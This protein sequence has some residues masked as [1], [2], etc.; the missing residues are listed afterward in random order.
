MVDYRVQA[1]VYA[2][3]RAFS[4]LVNNPNLVN[5]QILDADNL[6]SLGVSPG[7]IPSMQSAL[8]FLGVTNELDGVIDDNFYHLG[9]YV[10]ENSRTRAFNQI[11]TRAYR[12]LLSDVHVDELTRDKIKEHFEA[13]HSSEQVARKA[14]HFVMWFAAQAGF[15]LDERVRIYGM[16]QRLPGLVT[17]DSIRE[18]VVDEARQAIV[19]GLM[20]HDERFL[21]V[22]IDQLAKAEEPE[23]VGKLVDKIDEVMLRMRNTS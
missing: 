21:T 4:G 19:S 3:V 20:A 8:R 10:P 6:T 9:E 13:N 16:D 2:S 17:T 15:E 11:F 14:T 7:N 22:L 23:L 18:E 1:P 5:V 12:D